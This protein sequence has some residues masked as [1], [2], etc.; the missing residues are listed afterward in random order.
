[1]AEQLEHCKE[2]NDITIQLIIAVLETA[3]GEAD[4]ADPETAAVLAKAR[5]L[6]PAVKD[7][8]DKVTADRKGDAALVQD[9]LSFNYR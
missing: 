9:V 6:M 2:V 7:R 5:E 4:P 3:L 1:M 8:I